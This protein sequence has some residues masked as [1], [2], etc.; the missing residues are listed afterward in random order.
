M[1]Q[2]NPNLQPDK[3]EH[4]SAYVNDKFYENVFGKEPL[5]TDDTYGYNNSEKRR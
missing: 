5:N 3:N 4:Y 2:S 1:Q